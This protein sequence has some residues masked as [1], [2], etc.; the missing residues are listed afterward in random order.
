MASP[1]TVTPAEQP[2]SITPSEQVLWKIVRAATAFKSATEHWQQCQ[3][4]SVSLQRHIRRCSTVATVMHKVSTHATTFGSAAK[5]LGGVAAAVG[6]VSRVPALTSLGARMWR[7]G[8]TAKLAGLGGKVMAE[9]WEKGFKVTL[10]SYVSSVCGFLQSLTLFR[11]VLEE[12]EVL[13][14]AEFVVGRFMPLLLLVCPEELFPYACHV[15]KLFISPQDYSAMYDFATMAM[16]SFSCV[17]SVPLNL[18]HELESYHLLTVLDSLPRPLQLA[19]TAVHVGKEVMDL[20][21]GL[22]SMQSQDL[23]TVRK[24]LQRLKDL[25]V[26]L[27]NSVREVPLLNRPASV[28]DACL[29][30]PALDVSLANSVREVPMLNRPASVTD[31][32]LQPRALD[33]SLANSVREVPMLNRPA[34]VTDARLQ[35]RALDVSLANSVREVPLLN[36][37]VSVTDVHLQVQPSELGVSLVNGDR[38][39]PLLNRPVSVTDAYDLQPPA[40]DLDA[41]S[42]YQAL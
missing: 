31:A 5:V 13:M 21:A 38:E 36:R 2:G 6:V 16:S 34:S 42:N 27:V 26:S 10:T 33:V 23:Q 28:T 39:V 7:A 40:L 8:C 30:P 19:A 22:R 35:P 15:V 14:P 37:P 41:P 12:I 24:V 9:I 25:S 20:A 1:A 11:A 17:A 29:Q 18:L 3:R 4:R 32:R